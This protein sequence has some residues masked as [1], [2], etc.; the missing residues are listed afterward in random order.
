M[1][2]SR[3]IMMIHGDSDNDDTIECFLY[4]VGLSKA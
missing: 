1:S 4:V 2:N 3:E